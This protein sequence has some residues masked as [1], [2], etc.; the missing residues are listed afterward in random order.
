MPGPA[1]VVV[2]GAD[3]A[4]MSAAH[5]ALR[6]ARARGR[7]LDVVVLESTQHTSYSACGIP[8]WIAGDVEDPQR[9]LARSAGQHRQMGVDLRLGATATRLD[10]ASRQV[11]YRDER[12]ADA[13]LP[14]DELVLATGAPAVV[15]GWARAAGGALIGGVHPVK[16]LDDGATWLGL[17]GQ[18]DAGGRAAGRRAVVAGGGYIGVEM[19]E[20]MIRRGLQTTL[21]TRSAVMSSLD[22]DMST[23]ISA[24]LKEAGVEV[25]TGSR[26][27]SLTRGP[28]GAVAGAVTADGRVFPASVVVLGIG[29][30]PAS[31][32]GARAGLPLGRS[33]GYLPDARG[34]VGDGLWAAGDCCEA[35]HRITGEYA[36][37]PLGTHAN[38]Q[39]RV[40]GDNLSGG[41]A[42]FG[43]VLGTAITRFAAGGRHVEIAR[44]GLSTA[45]ALAAGL[46]VRSL[47]TEGTTA[48]G[49]M[50][51]AAPI[52]T[53][54]IAEPGT[55]RLLGAQIVGGSG[56]GKRIDSAAAALWGTM[57]VDDLAGM[58]LAYAPPFA[59]VWD[60]VQ[61]AARRLADQL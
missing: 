12:H 3:A 59:T 36:F 33:G 49:Y 13:R 7:D 45:E 55:R 26:V 34:Q 61:L 52:A 4:G 38:K 20:A 22:P 28:A 19:A 16:N 23:R 35:I 57:T 17:V 14:F 41:D 30:R 31:E 42:R 25:V 15:P 51:E 37:V 54:I 48:S 29:A 10:L 50:P 27:T 11:H 32:L 43:G 60:A 44:T 9:L 5:Q 56:A 1:R 24:A 58:D 8:Y 46:A 39:G 18:D 53:K 6:G 47:V 40:V 21:I 2:I